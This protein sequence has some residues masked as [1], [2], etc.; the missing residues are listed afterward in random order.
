[1]VTHPLT[2]GLKSCLTAVSHS[3]GGDIPANNEQDSFDC[4]AHNW[5]NDGIDFVE[6]CKTVLIVKLSR[7][8][9]D[10]WSLC[11]VCTVLMIVTMGR[12]IDKVLSQP[13]P[14][15]SRATSPPATTVIM[16]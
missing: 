4:Y 14:A 12:A 6:K 11:A 10:S 3:V 9:D 8:Q 13:P 2:V 1:M 7:V 16:S 5:I 15:S